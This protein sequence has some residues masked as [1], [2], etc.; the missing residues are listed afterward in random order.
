MKNTI[1]CLIIGHNELTFAEYEKGVREMG[2]KSGA[3]RD[4]NLS[5]FRY[6]DHLY[7]ATDIFNTITADESCNGSAIKPI[8][9]NE[10]F[11]ATIAYLG[12]YLDRRGF[13]FDYVNSFKREQDALAKKLKEENI[14]TIAIPTT[15]Y[16]TALP[17]MEIMNFVK[18]H[19][20]T[21]KILLGGPYISTQCRTADPAT[22]EFLF[23]SIGADVYVNSAQGETTLVKLIKAYKTGSPPSDINNIYYK[24]GDKYNSTSPLTENNNLGEN[25][26][27]WDLFSDRAGEYAN[28]RTSISCP[29]RCSFCGFPEH[30]GKYITA[31]I[32]AVEQELNGLNKIDSI[33]SVHFID[34][35]F[36]VPAKRFKDLLKMMI[37]NKYKFNWHSQLR[38]QFA[39]R[40]TLAL[41]KESGCE[42]V[43]LGI[44][45]GSD[46]ILDKMN[47]KTTVEKYLKGIELLREYD[48]LTYGSF[49]IGFPGET[50]ETV[51]ETIQFIEESQID[52]FRTQLWYC[53]PLTPIYTQKETYK[54]EGSHFEWKHSSMNAK[55]ACDII[56]HIFL[57]V[58]NSIWL[59]QQNFDFVNLFHLKNRGF[60]WANVKNYLRSFNGIIRQKL[61]NPAHGDPGT[62]D[63]AIRQMKEALN[64][65]DAFFPV[66]EDSRKP[67]PGMRIKKTDAP[68]Q[69]DLVIDFD[70]D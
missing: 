3:Y 33:K 67:E 17:I 21:A 7:H 13:T 47:K 15:L 45:S 24:D 56:D 40:E 8:P 46:K 30:A 41:M 70:L 14:I 22:L 52:F 51:Q 65:E 50:H 54:I 26:V 57:S 44:E 60:S 61:T 62:S 9:D 23:N 20:R 31:D 27:N 18:R 64:S 1:D 49:I 69:K 43:F 29:F 42:G 19:N 12:T 2:E 25:M 58:D 5:F 53:D 6:K 34:D 66:R 11:S 16:I 59:P 38:C 48:I 32:D 35:T 68:R 55:E 37:K 4:L 10:S 39:D 36:N 63:D 28:L